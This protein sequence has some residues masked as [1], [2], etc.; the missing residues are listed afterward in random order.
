[1]YF[2]GFTFHPELRTVV[3]AEWGRLERL[4]FC[5]QSCASL[6]SYDVKRQIEF[7]ATACFGNARNSFASIVTSLAVELHCQCDKFAVVGRAVAVAHEFV[8]PA[9]SPLR[10]RRRRSRFSASAW[11]VARL[12]EAQRAAPHVAGEDVAELA[13]PQQRRRPVGVALR[14]T[15]RLARCTR[16]AGTCTPARWCRRRSRAAF[17]LQRVDVARAELPW[18]QRGASSRAR[19]SRSAGGMRPRQQ[20]RLQAGDGFAVQAAAVRLGGSPKALV[21]RRP[22]CSSVSGSSA[23]QAP[24]KMKPL[25]FRSASAVKR[26]LR[27]PFRP[28][29]VCVAGGLGTLMSAA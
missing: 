27:T 28:A 2:K 26:G 18:H 15:L 19:A 29:G 4:S 8:A 9:A 5:V 17:R 10:T 7:S 6:P 14:A 3:V 20:N 21:D 24:T 22:G 11:I 25:W 13:A 1:M 16:R 23:W 12:L